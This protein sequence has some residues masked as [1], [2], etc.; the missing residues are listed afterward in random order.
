MDS[1]PRCRE[2]SPLQREEAASV[3]FFSRRETGSESDR[4]LGFGLNFFEGVKAASAELELEASVPAGIVG[5][6]ITGLGVVL[7]CGR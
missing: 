2:C 5:G 7:L 3:V 4:M 6:F 1:Q